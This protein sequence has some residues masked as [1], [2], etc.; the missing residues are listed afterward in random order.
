MTDVQRA[1]KPQFPTLGPVLLAAVLFGATAPLCKLLLGDAAP[2]PLAALLYLGSGVGLAAWMA[3]RR[4]AGASVDAGPGLSGTDWLVVGGA[5]AA[6]GV[7]APILFLLGLSHAEA[8]TASLLLNLEMVFTAVLAWTLFREGFEGRVAGGLV[9]VLA[10]CL[11][12]AWPAS[13]IQAVGAGV[14]PVAAACLCWGLDNNLTQRLADRDPIRI[15]AVKGLAGGSVSAALALLSGQAFPAAA[16]LLAALCVGLCG[17][18]ISLVLFI[19]SLGRIG[20]ARTIGAFAAAPFVG[21]GLSLLVLGEAPSLSLFV[22]AMVVLVGLVVALGGRHVHGHTH[23]TVVHA[24]RHQHDEHHKHAHQDGDG[25]DEPHEH[26]HSH[27]PLE[28]THPHY[29]DTHHRHGHS[30]PAQK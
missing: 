23:E 7:A 26:V 15:A 24:H 3:F 1:P 9:I 2:L 8:S 4:L 10:G 25:N 14:L 16:P 20:T 5:V 22:A 29:P 11:V 17:Y 19:V 12:L 21:A 13:G 6:G 27:Y 18:G 30:G 28:H